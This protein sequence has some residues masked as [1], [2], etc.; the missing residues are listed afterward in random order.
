ML[1]SESEIL[2]PQLKFQPPDLQLEFCVNAAKDTKQN[3]LLFLAATTLRATQEEAGPRGM[4]RSP[5]WNSAAES[6]ASYQPRGDRA[7]SR[8]SWRGC[9]AL[10]S[11]EE[12]KLKCPN[13]N[14]LGSN[15]QS[16]NLTKEAGPAGEKKSPSKLWRWPSP[17]HEKNSE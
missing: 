10:P 6:G 12:Q 7:R 16:N 11:A 14:H 17:H 15:P 2:I 1:S 5:S 9:G 4:T 13:G 8:H 3:H